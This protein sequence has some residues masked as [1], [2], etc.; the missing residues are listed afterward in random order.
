MD[1][2]FKQGAYIP[3]L[4]YCRFQPYLSFFLCY[5]YTFWTKGIQSRTYLLQYLTYLSFF[6]SLWIYNL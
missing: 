4:I 5:G 6:F 3:E 2:Q 1:L